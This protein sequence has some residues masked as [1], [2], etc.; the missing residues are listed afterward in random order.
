MVAALY[1]EP[2]GV[3]FGYGGVLEHP[4][5]SYAWVRYDLPRPQKGGGWSRTLLDEGWVC[6]VSQAAYGHPARKLTWLYYFGDADPRVL[7]KEAA[8][9]PEAF[10]DDLLRLIG[11]PEA[12]TS[13]AVSPPEGPRS[14]VA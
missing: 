5:Y 3:Y 1:V 9:T 11:K 10:R 6:E 7:K 14:S 12:V 8:R 13:E 2:G 4:A